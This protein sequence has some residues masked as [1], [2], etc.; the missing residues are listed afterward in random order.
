M[1]LPN[2]VYQLSILV[3]VRHLQSEKKINMQVAISVLLVGC[4]YAAYKLVKLNS[5]LGEFNGPKSNFIF[6]TTEFITSLAN[7]HTFFQRWATQ[8]GR[9]FRMRVLFTP[10]LVIASAKVGKEVL[11]AQNNYS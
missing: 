1:Y 7:I 5:Q 6:G 10:M 9:I 3:T 8:Y 4:S 11:L 2:F